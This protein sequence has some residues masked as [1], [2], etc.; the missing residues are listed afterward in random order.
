MNT[1][2]TILIFLIVFL[3]VL[4]FIKIYNTPSLPK[5]PQKY[6]NTTVKT[7]TPTTVP[8]NKT[9]ELPEGWNISGNTSASIITPRIIGGGN[10]L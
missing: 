10:W 1:F 9:P 8:T 6:R 3:L 2:T 5:C 4:I 7:Y